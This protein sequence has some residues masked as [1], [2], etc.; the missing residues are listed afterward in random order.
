MVC[1]RFVDANS[2]D[3][4]ASSQVISSSSSLQPSSRCS[5][6]R[7]V[8]LS[9]FRP[10]SS[11]YPAYTP[12]LSHRLTLITDRIP[13]R[14]RWL[15]V[16]GSPYRRLPG[17]GHLSRCTRYL[18]LKLISQAT[19]VH[20]RH[21]G[22]LLPAS[23]AQYPDHSFILENH[24]RSRGLGTFLPPPCPSCPS[25]RA[26]CSAYQISL[27]V[28]PNSIF[29]IPSHLTLQSFRPRSPSR[30]LVLLAWAMTMVPTSRS[31]S[32]HTL[33]STVY[34]MLLS[35]NSIHY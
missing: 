26:V 35:S 20:M 32:E 8:V 3:H 29:R 5:C 7:L 10:S 25:L 19:P 6:S 23:F 24:S 22:A 2:S 21:R 14:S 34:W 33:T 12:C 28:S 11:S 18:P 13:C 16:Y 17:R 15:Y 30:N 4:T 31:T 1:H 9:I 27:R